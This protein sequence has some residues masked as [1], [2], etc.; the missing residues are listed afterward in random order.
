MF[1][2]LVTSSGKT[3]QAPARAW[4]GDWQGWARDKLLLSDRKCTRIYSIPS[5]HLCKWHLETQCPSG[6]IRKMGLSTIL[7][8]TWIPE[9]ALNSLFQACPDVL[10]FYLHKFSRHRLSFVPLLST[11]TTSSGG[12]MLIVPIKFPNPTT[13]CL[14]WAT[15]LEGAQSWTDLQGQ[16]K[17]KSPVVLGLKWQR[18]TAPLWCHSWVSWA[19]RSHS[20][21]MSHGCRCCLLG[22]VTLSIFMNQPKEAET[23]RKFCFIFSRKHK[24][25]T[26]SSSI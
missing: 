12:S 9:A 10:F 14:C 5:S 7:S 22:L 13:Q 15:S 19:K 21:M 2:P 24:N 26:Y 4:E 17:E 11:Q 3:V 20:L 8:F 25:K 18:T 6:I 23:N 16:G 1:F